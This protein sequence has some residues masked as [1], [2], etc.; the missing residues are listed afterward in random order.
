MTGVSWSLNLVK[1][2][3]LELASGIIV[4]PAGILSFVASWDD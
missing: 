3:M 2:V 4:C 1:V